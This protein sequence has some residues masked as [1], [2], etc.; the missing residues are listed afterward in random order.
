MMNLANKISKFNRGRKYNHFLQMIKPGMDDK[1]LD[2][3]FT[4]NNY[5]EEANYLENI[6]HTKRILPH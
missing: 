3:G 1:I 2:V 4:E 5:S 6:I